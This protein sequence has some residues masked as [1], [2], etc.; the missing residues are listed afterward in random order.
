MDNNVTLIGNLT[1]AP[2]LRYTASGAPLCRLRLAVS[3]RWRNKQTGEWEEEAHFFAGSCW[4]D[5]AENVAESF[6]KGDRVI[7]V[8]R[9]QQRSWETS[10]GERRSLVE[11]AVTDM[12]PS[13]RWA[14]AQPHRIQPNRS[15]RDRDRDRDR[16]GG[17]DRDEVPF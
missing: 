6:N 1:E 11:V 12:G 4:R 8:G 3:R 17:Y 2:E 13:L 15:N 10:E 9:L 16:G 7:V 5:L 14:T